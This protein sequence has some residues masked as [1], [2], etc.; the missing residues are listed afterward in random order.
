M[1]PDNLKA[2]CIAAGLQV[3]DSRSLKFDIVLQLTLGGPPVAFGRKAEPA[4]WRGLSC[5]PLHAVANAYAAAGP[6][7][8]T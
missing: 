1:E 5:A 7:S 8:G 6:R 4:S 3:I 2:K